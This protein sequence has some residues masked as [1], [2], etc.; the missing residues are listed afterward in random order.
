MHQFGVMALELRHLRYFVV[1]AEVQNF[2]RA[3]DRLNIV[4]PALSRQIRD[5]E[6]QLGVAL[7]E[8][9]PRGVRLTPAGRSYAAEARKILAAVDTAK[10][11]AQRICRG[12]QGELRI[13]IS[14]L[15]GT[16]S[17]VMTA[18]RRF[19]SRLPLVNLQLQAM[20]TMAQVEA[21]HE[22]RLDVGLIFGFRNLPETLEL[23]E[24][25]SYRV[26]LAMPSDHRLAAYDTV[27]LADLRNDEFIISAVTPLVRDQLEIELR[28]LGFEPKVAQTVPSTEMALGLV[29]AGAGVA[30]VNSSNRTP[31][32]VVMK[33][34]AEIDLPRRLMIAWKRGEASALVTQFHDMIA[35]SGMELTD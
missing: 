13:G 23:H 4:Q 20:P 11:A 21:L 8:R 18:L 27:S 5:L 10:L 34:V 33:P 29:A 19:R 31:A 25:A 16:S 26:L 3:A 12:E 2:R 15:A 35:E 1:T 9:L 6:T 28:G 22:E 24:V 32:F 17:I 14:D 30:L 7:F